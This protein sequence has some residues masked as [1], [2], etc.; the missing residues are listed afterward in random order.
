M[1]HGLAFENESAVE[2]NCPEVV[3]F[4]FIYSGLIPL[5]NLICSRLVY[6]MSIF[7]FKLLVTKD[8]KQ[9]AVP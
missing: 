2:E 4:C 5:G 1:D 6:V 7:V 8:E 3:V 9:S